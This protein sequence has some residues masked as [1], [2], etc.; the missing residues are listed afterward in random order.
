ME[1]ATGVGQVSAR[2][3]PAGELAAAGVAALI[4]KKRLQQATPPVPGEAVGEIK[5]DVEQIRE[6]MRR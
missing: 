5:T 1:R 3:R 6:R 2:D 4:G